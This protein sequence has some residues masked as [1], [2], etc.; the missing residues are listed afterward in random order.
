MPVAGPERHQDRRID[1]LLGSIG[2][3][4]GLRGRT[5]EGESAVHLDPETSSVEMKEFVNAYGHRFG[6]DPNHA[7][8]FSYE[9][10]LFLRRALEK[11]QYGHIPLCTVLMQDHDMVGP[12]GSL[13]LIPSEDRILPCVV[14][15]V[16][17]GRFYVLHRLGETG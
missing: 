1:V 9:A 11:F 7:V 13:R 2:G 17:Q 16:A 15:T 5:V 14:A 4:H 3:A 10:V 8:V 12:T 6:K